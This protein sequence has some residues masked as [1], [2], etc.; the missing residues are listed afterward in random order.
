MMGFK[1][2]FCLLVSAILLM[3]SA[4]SF[5]N[6][7]LLYLVKVNQNTMNVNIYNVDKNIKVRYATASKLKEEI[8]GEYKGNAVVFTSVESGHQSSGYRIKAA[9]TEAEF[10]QAQKAGYKKVYF[11]VALTY[12]GNKPITL[13]NYNGTAF[14]DTFRS[15]QQDRQGKWIQYTMLLTSTMKKQLFDPQSGIAQEVV[16]FRTDISA[17]Y[18]KVAFNVYLGDVGFC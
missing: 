14:N 17:P 7:D 6:E 11:W 16:F 9:I 1:K 13:T 18:E 10:E 15:I 12:E 3:F 5:N 2:I 8:E 4:C